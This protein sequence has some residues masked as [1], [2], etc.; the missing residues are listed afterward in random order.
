MVKN[1]KKNEL[2][3][4]RVKSDLKREVFI[5]WPYCIKPGHLLLLSILF[6]GNSVKFNSKKQQNMSNSQ[7]NLFY[8]PL[9]PTKNRALSRP[10]DSLLLGTYYP[11]RDEPSKVIPIISEYIKNVNT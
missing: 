7:C 6:W 9:K 10:L 5:R 2:Q 4:T 11:V 3:K 1:C 8:A